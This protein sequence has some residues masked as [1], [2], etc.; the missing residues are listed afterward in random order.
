MNRQIHSST[1][2][3]MKAKTPGSSLPSG[4][5]VDLGV[6]PAQLQFMCLEAKNKI[7]IFSRGTGKSFIIGAEMDE[8]IRTM[9]RGITTIA[10]ATYGQALTKTLPSSFKMLEMLGYKRYDPKTKQGDYVVCR[11]PPDGWYRPYEHLLS[12]EHCITFSNGHAF[13]ILTQD[14]NSRGPNADFNIT[15]EALTLDKEQFDQEVAPTNRG[16][17]HI[18]GKLSLRP[19]KKHHGNLFMSSMPYEPKQKWLLEFAKYYEEERGIHLFDV[20]NRCVK[21]QM[22]L[23]EAKLSDDK[24][25]FREIWN[26][27]VR[28]RRTI[29]PFVS[30]DG[31]LFMLASIF[32]NIANVGMSYIINQ[33]KVMNKL[34]FLI[35][36]LNYV[37][38][39]IDNCYYN[40]HDVNKY[41]NATNDSFIRDFAENESFN[42]DALE[43]Q[44]S[45]FDAD[46]NPNKPIEICFDYGSSACFMEVAQPSNYDFATNTMYSNRIVD[47]TIN[48]FFVTPD[49]V[50]DTMVNSL[51][52]KFCYYYRYHNCKVVEMYRDRYGDARRANSSKTYNEAAIARLQKHGWTVNI[53]THRGMEPPQHEKYLLWSNITAEKDTRYPLKRFNATKCKYILV[54][55]NNTRVKQINGRFEKDKSSERNGSIL[56]QEAT[57]FGDVID[58]RVWTKYS[59]LMKSSFAFVDG[60]V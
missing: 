51:V 57:H 19:L 53:H 50:E 45:R 15:D 41:Y 44:D 54:S 14:G 29:Q 59:D 35:E 48:E 27:V 58:K 30:K 43:Q 18:W 33:Y 56:P 7:G 11:T 47:N 31:T 21:L 26:E 17:E 55:M 36:I 60:R 6:N 24:S 5:H 34:F 37:I 1:P 2:D 8:N 49:D 16:N 10:Q 28:L 23:I 52:D 32:D 40:L 22:Q 46:C 20:W 3:D 12:Y 4:Y 13:Y 39:K 9:P 25:L 42:W 38:D